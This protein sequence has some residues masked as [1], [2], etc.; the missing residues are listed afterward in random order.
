MMTMMI[1]PVIIMMTMMVVSNYDDNDDGVGDVST[2]FKP[3]PY[4]H[5]NIYITYYI[6]YYITYIIMPF[7]ETWVANRSAMLSAYM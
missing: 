4:L 6:F 3:C 7:L 5:Y 1:M 2:T